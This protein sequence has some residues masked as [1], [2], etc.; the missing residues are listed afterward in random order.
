[1]LITLSGHPTTNNASGQGYWGLREGSTLIGNPLFVA[2]QA[3]QEQ[4]S[5]HFLITGLTPGASKTYKWAQ[6]VLN[7]AHQSI[8]YVGGPASTS[9][10]GQAIMIVTEVP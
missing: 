9:G 10:V 8:L 1:M 5:A 2:H 7:G 3:Q 6:A 4:V